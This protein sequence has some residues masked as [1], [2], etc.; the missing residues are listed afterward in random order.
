V[1]FTLS[2][3]AGLQ[4]LP[5]EI[6]EIILEYVGGDA[7]FQALLS[8]GSFVKHPRDL[9]HLT[10]MDFSTMSHVCRA[11]REPAELMLYRSILWNGASR[12]STARICRL[13]DTM[14]IRP[15]LTQY[16]RHFQ[17][18]GSH[19]QT[20]VH[21]LSL[22]SRPSVVGSVRAVISNNITCLGPEWQEVLSWSRKRLKAVGIVRLMIYL[23]ES[24]QTL[25]LVEE[26]ASIVDAIFEAELSKMALPAYKSSCLSRLK[27]VVIDCE[28]DYTRGWKRRPKAFV[29]FR[30]LEFLLQ[31]PLIESI[32]VSYMGNGRLR[33]DVDPVQASKLRYLELP[34]CYMNVA[35]LGDVLDSCP[36]LQTL[37]YK[38]HYSP[39]GRWCNPP[40]AH[41][42]HYYYHLLNHALLK[43][44]DTLESLELLLDASESP[45][46]A[47]CFSNRPSFHC[48]PQ[49]SKMAHLMIEW[50][51]LKDDGM[52]AAVKLENLLPPEAIESRSYTMATSPDYGYSNI[53][54]W[55]KVALG[56]PRRLNS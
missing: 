44:K 18:S 37:R 35:S 7:G 11:L 28:K 3:M 15:H 48:L 49:L 10:L 13:L 36:Q 25:L 46:V 45:E 42:S 30:V 32:T 43:V 52:G 5:V 14:N 29:D 34:Y 16:V 1:T 2:I 17:A 38:G 24:L 12:I 40:D 56:P 21:D 50:P 39:Y 53:S 51:V 8:P 55:K 33:N 54:L 47:W 26:K 41:P 6:L 22:E 20:S 4:D 23:C 19:W 31:L 9:H 27:T